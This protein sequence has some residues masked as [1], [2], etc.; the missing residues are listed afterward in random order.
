MIDY[1][2]WFPIKLW[3]ENGVVKVRWS[4]CGGL[5]FTEPFFDE[6]VWKSRFP[7]HKDSQYAR[8]DSDTTPLLTLREKEQGIP[9]TGFIFHMS[10]CGSTLTSQML[11]ASSR[12]IVLSEA[13]PIDSV[14]RLENINSNEKEQLLLAIINALGRKKHPEE[15]RLFIKFE[16]WS[17][18]HLPLIKRLFPDVPW[19]FIYRNPIEVMVSHQR[20]RGIQ[21]VPGLIPLKHFGLPDALFNG[22]ALDEYGAKILSSICRSALFHFQNI[23]NGRLVNYS[24]LP[25][26]VEL[27]LRDHFKVDLA[28]GEA[29]AMHKVSSINAKDSLKTPFQNDLIAK[30]QSAT[31]ELT[32]LVE[33]F[34]MMEYRELEA[35]R[36]INVALRR[37]PVY[38]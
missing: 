33:T 14:L 29:E 25:E 5:R 4:F 31:P 6:S 2:D 16:S 3:R 24:Q 8:F 23:K 32:A 20:Q 26:E 28:A 10:R 19:I 18:F 35:Y 21:M 17:T 7:F 11:A 9:P 12:N 36:Q 37:F 34:L 38:T 15:N 13:S 22:C 30:A 27:L 1:K